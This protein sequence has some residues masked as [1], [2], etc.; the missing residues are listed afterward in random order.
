MTRLNLWPVERLKAAPRPG[1][2]THLGV[3]VAPT[4]YDHMEES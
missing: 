1:Y 3:P 4:F 2:Y